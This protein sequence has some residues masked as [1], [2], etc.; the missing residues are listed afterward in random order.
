LRLFDNDPKGKLITHIPIKVRPI[1]QDEISF[2][3]ITNTIKPAKIF[4]VKIE[5]SIKVNP[6][7]WVGIFKKG[8]SKNDDTGYESYEYYETNK[9]NIIQL[10]APNKTGDFEL[11]LYSNDPGT[12]I[13]SIPF[14]IG[15]L[16]LEGI[17]FR[18]Q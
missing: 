1:Y 8:H 4:E 13:K 12:I 10:T 16:N 17:K 9:S 18:T 2:S 11:R 7:A 15:E 14:R 6:K 5:N 3:I